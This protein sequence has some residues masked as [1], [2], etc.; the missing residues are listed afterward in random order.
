MPKPHTPTNPAEP[1]PTD[2][3]PL[4]K[5]FSPN[6]STFAILLTVS[7]IC[8]FV[9]IVSGMNAISKYASP[10]G[11]LDVL[12]PE[13]RL[14]AARTAGMIGISNLL[15]SLGASLG[16]WFQKSVQ[17]VIYENGFVSKRGLKKSQAK[18]DEVESVVEH[19]VSR[20]RNGPR[21]NR[22]HTIVRTYDGQ[23][24]LI[25]GLNHIRQIGE[26]IARRSRRVLKKAE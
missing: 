14:G 22:F 18:W 10:P 5:R 16:A 20:K 15:I 21:A 23:E 12:N 13:I 6:I 1:K 8:F 7:I 17:V 24:V 19:F 26:T 2:L 4:V 11:T 9:A 25:Q 3:G